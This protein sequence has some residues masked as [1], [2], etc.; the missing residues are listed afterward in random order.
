M[1]LEEYTL[2]TALVTPMKGDGQVDFQDLETLVRRQER[3]GN[4]IVL[5]GSTGEGLALDFDEKAEVVDYVMNLKPECPIMVGVGG[6]NIEAQERWVSYCSDR[7]VDGFL[8]VAP[9]YSKPGPV[10]MEQW[11]RR[12]LDRAG[13]PCM[14]YNIPGRTGVRI[15]PSVIGKLASHPAVWGL[16]EASGSLEEFRAFRSAAPD[17]AIY[18]G[19]DALLPVF[20]GSGCR[21]LV[22]V[23]ANVWPEAT[24]AYVRLCLN[25]ECDS[26][27]GVWERG[28]EVL[29]SAS[30][31]IPAKMLLLE[32]GL[33]K[34][35][36]LRLPLVPE[37]IS[38]TRPLVE[39]DRAVK[40]WYEQQKTADI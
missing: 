3:A 18:S 36:A 26:F 29:F 33:I 4:G 14:L 19:D 35:P 38:D 25:G 34:S 40:A 39:A 5:L 12:L 17:L 21:G 28:A 16:K 23:A 7:D 20:A 32:K 37:E 1:K 24:A 10:G 13:R 31:P 2:W 30:N 22:S 27:E 9:L 8:M 11:F 6:F 15:P